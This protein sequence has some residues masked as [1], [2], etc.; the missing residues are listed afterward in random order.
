MSIKLDKTRRR[1]KALDHS[2]NPGMIKQDGINGEVYHQQAK[3][4]GMVNNKQDDK[5]KGPE[6][7]PGST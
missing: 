7:G 1:V 5:D 3:R 6:S 4:D 2:F